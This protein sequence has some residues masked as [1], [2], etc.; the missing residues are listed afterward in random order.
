MTP[1][2]I[3][4]DVRAEHPSNAVE[5]TVN[6]YIAEQ[7]KF[8]EVIPEFQKACGPMLV[9]ESGRAMDVRLVALTKAY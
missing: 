8:T 3:P 1:A 6:E 9:S 5:A 2:G 4:K 7:S